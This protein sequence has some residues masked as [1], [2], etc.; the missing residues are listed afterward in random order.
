[1][2]NVSVKLLDEIWMRFESKVSKHQKPDA[3]SVAPRST[4]IHL[5][6][7]SEHTEPRKKKMVGTES[8]P[9]LIVKYLFDHVYFMG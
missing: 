2:G 6:Q 8:R 9:V 7:T 1:M 5:K 4:S 3:A